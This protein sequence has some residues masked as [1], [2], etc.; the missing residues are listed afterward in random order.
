MQ[1]MRSQ[2]VTTCCLELASEHLFRNYLILIEVRL[3]AE[4]DAESTDDRGDRSCTQHGKSQDISCDL[5]Q[6]Q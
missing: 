2:S 5:N 4:E 6:Q 3:S 1:V